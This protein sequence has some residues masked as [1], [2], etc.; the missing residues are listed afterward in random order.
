ASA[1]VRP[2]RAAGPGPSCG[3]GVLLRAEASSVTAASRA[4]PE[5]LT[6]SS[7]TWTG[8]RTP[9]SARRRV[10]TSTV[11]VSAP[12]SQVATRPARTTTTG[13]REATPRA[14][15]R[16]SGRIG[17]TASTTSTAISGRS[18]GPASTITRT[19]APASAESAADTAGAAESLGPRT[20]TVSGPVTA[21]PS[22]PARTA[23][24]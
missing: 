22:R 5:P 15:S 20:A 12:G 6:R 9:A 23:P 11:P 17:Q 18:P 24:P 16:S 10:V 4:A 2:G 1:T 13:T 19:A 14:T 21:G 7:T 8:A 3:A